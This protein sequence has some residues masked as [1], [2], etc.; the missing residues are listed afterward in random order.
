MTLTRG[1]EETVTARGQLPS[2]IGLSVREGRSAVVWLIGAAILFG[3]G[4]IGI[5]GRRAMHDKL[6][7]AGGDWHEE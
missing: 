3:I 7:F 4:W 1:P 6:R 2:W 5:T